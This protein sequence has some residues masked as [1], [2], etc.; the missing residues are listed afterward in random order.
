[1]TMTDLIGQ[2]QERATRSR[3][4][5]VLPEGMDERVMRA[6]GKID[7]AA[8]AKVIVL[9]KPMALRQ[10]ADDCRVSLANITT[11]DPAKSGQLGAVTQ[12][13]GRRSFAEGM[14]DEELHNYA[15]EPV[16][17]GAAL[18]ALG[19]ADGM[20]AGAATASSEVVRSAIRI[21][22]LAPGTDLVSSIFLMISPDGESA[23]TFSDCGVVP[24]PDAAQL[25]AIA[26]DA[27]DFHY[28]LTGLEPRVAFLSFSSHGSAS[29]RMV[30]KPGEAA[31]L[32]KELRPDIR[33]DGELQTDSAIVPSVAR[34]KVPGSALE[35]LANVLIFPDLNAG[36]I[37]YKLT[38]RLGGYT[39]LGPLLQ[40]LAKPVH[41]LSRGCTA[42]DIVQIVA[43]AALQSAESA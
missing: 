29:H 23:L 3:A 18:V 13:L 33:S 15:V 20:V 10:M 42:D 5:V 39:A 37:G 6:A 21:V 22:G 41:D 32:F 35:G 28:L 4:T 7:A 19:H 31:R 25:C 34:M 11:L 12:S 17:F 1:M 40:G 14:S 27:A 26:S 9:G 30:D 24:D 8:T 36:N 43:I 38:E 2:L 16:H